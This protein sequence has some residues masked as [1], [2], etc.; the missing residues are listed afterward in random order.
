MTAFE[1]FDTEEVRNGRG[2][3][4]LYPATS[5]GAVVSARRKETR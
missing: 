3:F 4:G 1:D 2:I 5:Q